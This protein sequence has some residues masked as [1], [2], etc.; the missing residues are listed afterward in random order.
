ME[1][2]TRK[3]SILVPIL[4]SLILMIL[5]AGGVYIWQQKVWQQEKVT[6]LEE[7]IEKLKLDFAEAENKPQQETSADNDLS[8]VDFP[9]VVFSRP[10][11]LTEAERKVLEAKLINP[12]KDYYNE[13]EA[14]L[15]TLSIAVPQR[16]GEEYTVDGIFK[17]GVNFG[18]LFGK[19]E[20]QYNFWKPE[21]MGP[22]EFS[23]TFK[24]KYPTIVQE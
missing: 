2:T 13:T 6:S 7:V 19:R 4:I 3:S 23:E 15:L 24:S 17:D 16:V 18:M 11:L 1:N 8:E 9:V 21:C 10:G 12:M 14:E 5:T 20:Q 22:C